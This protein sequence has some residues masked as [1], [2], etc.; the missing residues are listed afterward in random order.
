MCRQEEGFCPERDSRTT[1]DRVAP[2]SS[3]IMKIAKIPPKDEFSKHGNGGGNLGYDVE[4]GRSPSNEKRCS[5]INE[6]RCV[7]QREKLCPTTR[8]DAPNN[9]KRYGQQREKV[10]ARKKKRRSTTRSGSS[11]SGRNTPPLPFVA[12]QIGLSSGKSSL[13]LRPHHEVAPALVHVCRKN[14]WL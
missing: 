5:P 6:K 10:C 3:W 1:E 8:K 14:A 4:N 12:F 2:S 7:Q 13:E 9:E 11:S